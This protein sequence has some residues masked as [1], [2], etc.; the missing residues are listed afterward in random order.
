MTDQ[1]V[2]ERTQRRLNTCS[3]C[4]HWSLKGSYGDIDED[5]GKCYAHDC[6]STKGSFVCPDYQ[7]AVWLP[8]SI[9]NMRKY[10][11]ARGIS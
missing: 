6:Q 7:Q 10:Y 9:E 1:E 2:M 4:E 5:Y 3:T 11:A 8:E